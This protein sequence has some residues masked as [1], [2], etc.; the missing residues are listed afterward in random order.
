MD[1]VDPMDQ[2]PA[3]Q[4]T[5][6]SRLTASTPSTPSTPSTHCRTLALL[7]LA[8]L[9]LACACNDGAQPGPDASLPGADAATVQPDAGPV[10]GPDAGR[11]CPGGRSP[12]GQACCD[13]A[14]ETC[15]GNTCTRRSCAA[16]EVTCGTGCCNRA[17]EYCDSTNA[18]HALATCNTRE[19]A[20]GEACCDS[21]TSYCALAATSTCDLLT[22][23][24]TKQTVCG[25]RCCNPPAET[26]DLTTHACKAAPVACDPLAPTACTIA[27][28]CQLA[29]EAQWTCDAAG[30]ALEGQSCSSANLCAA[31]LDC[32]GSLF[33]AYCFRYCEVRD[34]RP[35]RGGVCGDVFEDGRVGIC[36]CDPLSQLGCEV[37]EACHL[38]GVAPTCEPPGPGV[39]GDAC[40]YDRDCGVGLTCGFAGTCAAFCDPWVPLDCNPARGGTGCIR[41]S[42]FL[43]FCGEPCDPL[44]Q[45]CADPGDACF[46]SPVTAGFCA[47]AGT[48]AD[49]ERCD[50]P[51]SCR[52]GSNCMQ[53]AKDGDYRCLPLCSTKNRTCG[54]GG[55]CVALGTEGLGGCVSPVC[56]PVAQLGCGAGQACYWNEAALAYA[57]AAS[58]T[59]P[60]DTACAA[61][62]ECMPGLTCI[63]QCVPY[64]RPQS[65]ASV[66]AGERATCRD[67][68]G[69]GF[70]ACV[71]DLCD[72]RAQDCADAAKACYP[73]DTGYFCAAPGTTAD[74]LTCTELSDCRKGSTCLGS[75]QSKQCYRLCDATAATDLCAATSQTCIAFSGSVGVC[76]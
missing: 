51:T 26:C 16:S 36:L 22:T 58:G 13:D 17:T 19:V 7:S 57:C 62:A 11:S 73:A 45:S 55:S 59:L 6:S 33:E 23:C 54:N 41:L 30:T 5:A 1:R 72:P 69:T 35:C 4:R 65:P 2:M 9:V 56:D 60:L 70:G 34:D 25:S 71:N 40:L 21:R 3:R 31:G 53:T 61:D 42:N 37:T 18:C 20:C 44:K 48:T 43:G 10:P 52:K 49:G 28:S 74:G 24:M 63:G 32:L 15:A 75:S 64:C 68:L 29:G 27:E 38:N 76:Y 67:Y 12:C 50:S 14:T 39:V 46:A 66:C 8:A 47:K